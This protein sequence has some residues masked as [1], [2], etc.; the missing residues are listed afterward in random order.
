[1]SYKTGLREIA[2]SMGYDLV[3]YDHQFHPRARKAKFLELFGINTVLDVGANTGQYASE[4]RDIGYHGKI[5][6]FEPLD[7]AFKVLQNNAADDN[8]WEVFRY[9]LGDQDEAGKIN[10]SANSVSSS[11]LPMLPA[12]DEAAIGSSYVTEQNIQIRK[13]DSLYA[14]LC[15]G[16][17]NIYLKIDAQGFEKKVMDGAQDSLPKID[18]VEL[19]ISL[20]PLYE[21]A[22][23]F[24]QLQSYMQENGYD[25]IGLEPGFSAPDTGRMLQIDGIYHRY[26]QLISD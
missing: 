21:G 25:L 3:R 17:R 6:S 8:D 1:M 16:A 4:L 11:I 5:K 23:T 24:D 26:S 18:T 9:A 14:D 2:R 15:D 13:L 20:T 10:V 12:H 7:D 22:P 19:E